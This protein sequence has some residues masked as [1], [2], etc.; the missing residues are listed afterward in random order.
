[1]APVSALELSL[2]TGDQEEGVGQEVSAG[3]V[4]AE[5]GGGNHFE[6]IFFTVVNTK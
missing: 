6:S 4:S 3:E 5:L 2:G 1:M